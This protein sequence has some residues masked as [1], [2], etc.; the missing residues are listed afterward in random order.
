MKLYRARPIGRPRAP[1]KRCNSQVFESPG[2]GFLRG[3][4]AESRLRDTDTCRERI[5]GPTELSSTEMRTLRSVSV[6]IVVYIALRSCACSLLMSEIRVGVHVTSP[7]HTC[8]H[9][10][11]VWTRDWCGPL[12]C[13]QKVESAVSAGSTAAVNGN[14]HCSGE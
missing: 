14:A 10:R 9:Q 7:R 13:G 12:W 3:L 4:R 8:M 11:K 6:S 5:L 2:K 1:N